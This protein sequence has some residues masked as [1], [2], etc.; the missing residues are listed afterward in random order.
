MFFDNQDLTPSTRSSTSESTSESP[1]LLGEEHKGRQGWP[2]EDHLLASME[3]KEG[4]GHI[5]GG[6]GVQVACTSV[7]QGEE[8]G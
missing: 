1:S 8:K 4:A 5:L 3:S 6:V 2:G 7:S